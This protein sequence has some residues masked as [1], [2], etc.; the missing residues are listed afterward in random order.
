MISM[1]VVTS[2]NEAVKYFTEHDYYSGDDAEQV[3]SSWYGKGA[4]KLEL[5]GA[6][7]KQ[8]MA[9]LLDGR[10]SESEQLGKRNSQGEL[11]HKKGWDLTF[12]APKSVSILALV[13]KDNRL[14]DVHNKAVRTTLDYL[15]KELVSTRKTIQGITTPEKTGNITVAQFQ[16]KTSRALDMQLHTHN[17]VMNI[18]HDSEKYKSIESRNIYDTS[19]LLGQIYQNELAKN[20]REIGYGIEFD[21]QKGTFEVEGVPKE[22]IKQMS[23]RRSDIEQA[24]EKYGYSSARGMGDAALR[25]RDKKQHVDESVLQ[26]KWQAE[27]E[28]SG[29]DPGSLIEK[30]NGA[31]G[32]VRSITEAVK[33]FFRRSQPIEAV[34]F[35]YRNMMYHEASIRKSDLIL[36][37]LKW[38]MGNVTVA[39]INKAVDRLETKGEL[40]KRQV[41]NADGFTS[42]EEIK[43]EQDIIR[44]MQEGKG[45]FRAAAANSFIEA[46]LKDQGLTPGQ[47]KAA[48]HILKS[49]DLVTGVQ[50]YAGT[51]KTSMLKQVNTII[52]AVRSVA[53]DKTVR[54]F[55]FAPTGAASRELKGS[56]LES[57]TLASHLHNLRMNRNPS[58]YRNNIWFVDEASMVN[59]SD[60]KTLLEHANR[61]NSKVVLLG[62]VKQ[63]SA[64]QAGKPF[65]QLLQHGMDHT[66]MKDIMRQKDSP[67]LLGAVKDSIENRIQ[68]SFRKLGGSI[69][70][71]SD[72]EKRINAL[73]KHY[74]FMSREQQ[75]STLVLIPDNDTRNAV[76]D[77]IRTQ[78]RQ[79][80]RIATDDHTFT[81]HTSARL[82]PL[83]MTKG[84]F[85]KPGMVVQFNRDYAAFGVKKGDML[86]VVNIKKDR[87][88]LKNAK[89]REQSVS[90]QKIRF[91]NPGNIEVYEKMDRKISVGDVIRIK[92]TDKDK[93]LLN[94][95]QGKVVKIN[96]DNV[97]L[98][99][100]KN[101]E[102]N[103]NLKE[104]RTWEHGYASTTY[105]AQGA[106]SK[107]VI[108]MM[109]SYRKNLVNSRS[110]YVSISRAKENVAVYTDNKQKT[111]E[112]IQ[113]RQGQKES[114]LVDA[115]GFVSIAVNERPEKNLTREKSYSMS[116]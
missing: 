49:T 37:T 51:G 7:D 114:A 17:V 45:R 52:A 106:T 54:E 96:G 59:S 1:K 82:T 57:G 72:R 111:M 43:K 90:T 71:I 20:V 66:V 42:K 30:A 18:T 101:G 84:Q 105:A 89:G 16:H 79:E 4:E 31:P 109:E 115:E 69:H 6:V 56:G 41:D 8:E 70:E 91:M 29:F 53:T 112:G 65:E 62:D 73:V 67:G 76:Q 88:T 113:N 11:T 44:I 103:I 93:G 81:T 50:G 46:S 85:Y 27:L 68:S 36:N 94:G 48:T 61:L 116:R 3:E 60:M 80:G 15:E 99:T 13:G 35:A 24:A 92:K 75:K 39:D 22:V 64:I 74:F 40:V 23:K 12:S 100:D 104:F 77:R 87:L 34:R 97:T 86:D 47:H 5:S 98:R 28:Q 107:N 95:D 110:F 58:A 26:K 9:R 2:T 25:T 102:K 63:L 78:L 21:P 108:A 55:G 19:R 83:Q 38:T 10:I 14:V 32:K 33:G